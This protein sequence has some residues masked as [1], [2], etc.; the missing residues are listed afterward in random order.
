MRARPQ[1]SNNMRCA[2]KE[3][4]SLVTDEAYLKREN[5]LPED[6]RSQRPGLEGGECPTSV[7]FVLFNLVVQFNPLIVVLH[8]EQCH[9]W[10]IL[11]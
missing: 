9:R 7:A 4:I 3:H 11:Q 6:I 2:I 5:V 1:V 10:I 8:I